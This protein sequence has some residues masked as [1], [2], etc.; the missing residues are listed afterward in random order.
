LICGFVTCQAEDLS[1]LPGNT[2]ANMLRDALRT[3]VHA[4]LDKRLE[5]MEALKSP[6]EIKA[7]QE[8]LRKRFVDSLGGYPERTP[9]NPKI[10]G[11]IDADGYRIEKLIY[12]SRPKFFVTALLYLPDGDGPFP[13]VL[14][15]CGHSANGKAYSAYQ[16]ICIMLAKHGMAALCYDP[17]GQGER[18]QI[19]ERDDAGNVKIPFK[20]TSEHNVTGVAPILL[21][22]GLATYRI[23]DGMRSLDYLASR[24][25]IDPDRLGC[26]GNSGGGLMTSYL[27][28]LD[29]R[30][31]AAAP[32]C[33]ITT[34][35]IKNER[36]G[37]GDA[38]QNIFGQTGYGLDHADYVML[39]AP[40]AVLICSA[41]NDFVPIEGA[42]NSFRQAK[43][44]YTKLGISERVSLVEAD[45]K[46]GYTQPLRIAATQW[47]QRW[48]RGIDEP[49][50]EPEFSIH[51]DE[52]LQC[53]PEGQ[54]LLLEGARS[55]YD[56]YREKAELLAKERKARN[57]Q[58]SD[59]ELRDLIRTTAGIHTLDELK[60]T[61]IKLS[62]RIE[63]DGYRI[64]KLTLNPKPG[65]LLPALLFRPEKP[66]GKATLYLHGEGKH[67][68]A[69]VG[70]PIAKLVKSGQT[71]LA[72][73]LRGY[74]ETESPAWRYSGK[75]SGPNAAEY[76]ISYMLGQSLVGSRANDI[77][78]STQY[79]QSQVPE[80]KQ[81]ELV[82]V[83][84]AVVPV[85]HAAAVSPELY[86]SMTLRE[87]LVSWQSVIETEVTIDQLEN[88]VHGALRYYDLPDLVKMVGKE[89]VTVESSRGA[90]GELVKE[91]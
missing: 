38:E 49:V 61:R 16:R 3:Q 21:G 56:L 28:A 11:T 86:D 18:N 53:T 89:K 77:L 1:V 62:G 22:E 76:F 64:D 79:L 8:D 71:V 75:Y 34:T 14:V 66:N 24:P 42:W 74:G 37:P 13:G 88:T 32:G 40:R 70:G 30:I 46:H 50:T 80:A 72:V 29:E 19:L 2:D 23:W 17:V 45:E 35:R 59:D 58:R 7:W 73:D 82:A 69:G 33:F 83:K 55:L 43:R 44:L 51:T 54:V 81:V 41:T 60:S 20:S 85:L 5:R 25:E 52:E 91:K 84:D 36:P 87:G 4:A 26:T 6:E 47:F 12:E 78:I 90:D 31:K 67:V 15:P 68:D 65:I 10:V 27:V 63:R 39:A 48:L 57:E 9:L